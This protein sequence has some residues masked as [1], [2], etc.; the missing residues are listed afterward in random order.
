VLPPPLK[1]FWASHGTRILGWCAVLGTALYVIADEI[2]DI[3]PPTGRLYFK[4]AV[5]LWG[6]FVIRRGTF[7]AGNS[8]AVRELPRGPP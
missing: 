2:L 5:T 7:N 4:A 1:V 6:Y 3:I 8:Q